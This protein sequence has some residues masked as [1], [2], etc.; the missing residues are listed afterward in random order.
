MWLCNPKGFSVF[1]PVQPGNILIELPTL[2]ICI[3]L[4]SAPGLG[5]CCLPSPLEHLLPRHSGFP[6]LVPTMLE[7]FGPRAGHGPTGASLPPSLPPSPFPGQPRRRLESKGNSSVVASG[8]SWLPPFPQT[9]GACAP[10][11]LPQLL[12]MPCLQLP[13]PLGLFPWELA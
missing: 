12:S 3:S 10:L 7:A 13:E 8:C 5:F 9:L 4:T 11:G 2:L 6:E 1:I